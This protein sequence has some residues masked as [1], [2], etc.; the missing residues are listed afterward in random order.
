MNNLQLAIER[1]NEIPG[2][3]KAIENGVL[4]GEIEPLELLQIQTSFNR[5][6]EY[7]KKNKE[8][9]KAFQSAYDKRVTG[10]QKEIDF[11]GSKITFNSGRSTYDFSKIENHNYRSLCKE[12]EYYKQQKEILEAEFINNLKKEPIVIEETGEIITQEVP[13]VKTGESYFSVKL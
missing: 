1:K 13:I 4:N 2:V 12:F 3:L 5:W 8:L 11:N 10:N 7:I 9:Q 6:C